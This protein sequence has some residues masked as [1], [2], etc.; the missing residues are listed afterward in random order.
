M[1]HV[2]CGPPIAAND[3]LSAVQ[4]DLDEAKVQIGLLE[5]LRHS[6]LSNLQAMS[7]GAGAYVVTTEGLG[8]STLEGLV[9]GG[10]TFLITE[11]GPKLIRWVF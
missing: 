4:S 1:R 11:G 9:A 7:L 6:G 3:L 2:P 10:A 5:N 8:G